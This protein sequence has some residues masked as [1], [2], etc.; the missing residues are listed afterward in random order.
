MCPFVSG[1]E[2]LAARRIG[3]LGGSF[4]PAHEGHR[5]ISMLALKRLRLDEVWWMITPQNPL[6]STREMAP[7]DE[8]LKA[9]TRVA[10]HPRIRVT[11]VERRLGTAHTADSL[12]LLLPRFPKCRFVW[13]MGADNLQQV[14]G[15]KDWKRLFRLIPI[16]V[17]SRPPYS[18]LALTARSARVFADARVVEPLARSIV[19]MPPPAW[20][21][22]NIRPHAASATRIRA[23]RA[24]SDV[25]RAK[26][27]AG[28]AERQSMEARET[29]MTMERR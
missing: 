21:F 7:F 25:D 29:M 20:V 17:F 8:R 24:V 19:T 6:K 15:W 12:A 3:L 4:N 27:R 5:H 9:A 16:A 26:A 23:R 14:S 2:A 13:L 11:D 10:R 1:R 22:L 28:A 18:K